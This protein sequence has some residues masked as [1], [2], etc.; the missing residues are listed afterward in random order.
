MDSQDYISKLADVVNLNLDS[1]IK[2]R[3]SQP[4][5]DVKM[6]IEELKNVLEQARMELDD[7]KRVKAVLISEIL[8]EQE[9][10][11]IPEISFE[12]VE[13]DCKIFLENLRKREI[14][15]EMEEDRIRAERILYESKILELKKIGSKFLKDIK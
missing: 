5:K 1:K 10:M 2:N 12:K 9:T 15:W 7:I 6:I 8:S 11:R 13:N 3:L 14:E 4:E